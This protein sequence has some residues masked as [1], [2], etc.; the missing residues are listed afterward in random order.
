MPRRILE[1]VV[2]SDKMDKTV[3]VRVER[4]IQHPIYKK[5]MKRS[6][7]F[8]AHDET[9]S[10]KEGD[11]VKILESKPL[12]KNKKWEVISTNN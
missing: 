11:T 7:K 9:N 5:F 4:Y 8:M 10:F 12:S 1:G 6:K 2:V 3:V